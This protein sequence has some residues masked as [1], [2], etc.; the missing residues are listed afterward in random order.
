M[1]TRLANISGFSL[2]EIV[3]VIVVLGIV[4]GIAMQSMTATIDDIRLVETEREMEMLAKAIVGDPSIRTAGARSDFGY[5]GDVGQF[6]PNLQALYQNPGGY[7]TWDGPY[8]PP[9]FTQDNTSFNIDAWGSVYNYSGGITITSTGS[10]SNIVQ[11]IAGATSDYTSNTFAGTIRDAAD[12][13]PG[14]TYMDSVD[15]KITIP[16][17]PSFLT[18]TYAPDSAGA[19]ALDAIPVGTH[20]LRIIF[21]PASDTLFRYLTILPRH[22]GG[23][24]FQFASVH[25]TADPPST[26]SEILR[27]DGDGS[28]TNLTLSGCAGNYQCV[29]EAVSDGN[30]T[31]VERAT[32]SFATDLYTMDDPVDTNGTITGLTVYCRAMKTQNSGQVQPTVYLG[33]S[34]YNGPAQDIAASWIDYSKQWTTSPATGSAW[35]WQEVINLEAGLAL[36]GQNSNFPAYCTQVWVEVT[37]TY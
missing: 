15:I 34:E 13:V 24:D 36:K 21:A 25:F 20:P 31:Y 37:Y 32:N 8:I 17:G 18:R 26:G 2:I 29:N 28:E 4:A 33:G 7:T 6:P 14:L 3:V 23:K 27:P 30:G 16:S 11:K 5:V 19:F 9:G 35:T 1:I 22:K 12:S 10:G